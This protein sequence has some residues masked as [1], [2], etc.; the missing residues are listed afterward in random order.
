M[1]NLKES[2]TIRPTKINNNKKWHGDKDSLHSGMMA[3]DF[4]QKINWN[5]NFH[6]LQVFSRNFFSISVQKKLDTNTFQKSYRHSENVLFKIDFSINSKF[7]LKPAPSSA[8][9]VEAT[10]T[11]Q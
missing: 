7:R 5:Q 3:S 9:L 11:I 10:S 2:T 1:I 6:S 4:Q 8:S